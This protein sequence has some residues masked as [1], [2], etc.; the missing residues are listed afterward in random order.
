MVLPREPD[1]AL[2]GSKDNLFQAVIENA[3]L[4][5]RNNEQQLHLD[6]FEPKE[7]LKPAQLPARVSGGHRRGCY[8]SRFQRR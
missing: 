2:I 6:D 4:D 5:I 3:Y 7:A 8:A 1:Q